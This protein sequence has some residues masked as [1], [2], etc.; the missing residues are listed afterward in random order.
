MTPT[1][2]KRSP[3]PPLGTGCQF[4]VGFPEPLIGEIDIRE[5]LVGG[6]EG[7]INKT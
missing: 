3:P 7:A 1:R 6:I 5:V 2:A 4:G